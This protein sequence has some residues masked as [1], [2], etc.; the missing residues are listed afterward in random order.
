MIKTPVVSEDEDEDIP[1]TQDKIQGKAQ[2]KAQ[3]NNQDK[4]Q[5]IVTEEEPLKNVC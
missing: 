4:T 2:D 3:D 5:F 1:T